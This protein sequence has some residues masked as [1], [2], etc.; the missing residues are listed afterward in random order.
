[1]RVTTLLRPGRNELRLFQNLFLP[2]VKLAA[3]VRVGSRYRRRYEA[4]RTPF[5]RLA[6]WPQ[7]DPARV[8]HLQR[9]R[10]SLDPFQLSR[11]I[12]TKLDSIYQLNAEAPSRLLPESRFSPLPQLFTGVHRKKKEAKKK[13]QARLRRVTSY[14]A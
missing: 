12:Q 7:A 8:A 3:K 1:M 6:A 5:Q 14:V 11:T 2:S 13:E 9:L 4:P 10:D